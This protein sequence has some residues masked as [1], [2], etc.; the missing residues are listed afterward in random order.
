MT[1]HTIE[2]LIFSD[3]H[4]EDYLVQFQSWNMTGTVIIISKT[5]K[6]Q[7][8]FWHFSQTRFYRGSLF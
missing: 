6:K 2:A 8:K 5:F 7:S 1:S 3:Q 4:S